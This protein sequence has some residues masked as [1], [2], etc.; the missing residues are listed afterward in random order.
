MM[1]TSTEKASKLLNRFLTQEQRICLKINGYIKTIGSAGNS[2]VIVWPDSYVVSVRR[3]MLEHFD[4]V[5]CVH[6]Q[7]LQ[8][9]G[10]PNADALL[11]VMLLIE[12][13]EAVF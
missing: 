8:S 1:E 9:S 6:F 12:K 7:P 13:H 3:Q 10:L 5:G 2:W 11:A 4:V